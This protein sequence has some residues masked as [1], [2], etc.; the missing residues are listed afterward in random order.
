M[1]NEESK[2]IEKLLSEINKKLDILIEIQILDKSEDDQLK[3]LKRLGYS[4]KD[5]SEFT[6]I[7]YSSIRHR[8]G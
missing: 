6:G 3:M 2:S 1:S 7:S 4:S 5:A 8:K